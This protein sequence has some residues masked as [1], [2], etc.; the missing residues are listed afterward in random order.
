MKVVISRTDYRDKK[1]VFS[2][3]RDGYSFSDH[4]IWGEETS[5]DPFQDSK[6]KFDVKSTSSQQ[7]LKNVEKMAKKHRFRQCFLLFLK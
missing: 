5:D 4:D 2:T 3:P 1:M 6:T 7:S